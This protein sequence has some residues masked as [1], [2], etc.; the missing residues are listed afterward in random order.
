MCLLFGGAGLNVC[1]ILVCIYKHRMLAKFYGQRGH[2]ISKFPKSQDFPNV[3]AS[4]FIVMKYV[5]CLLNICIQTPDVN[6][7]HWQRCHE[8][9]LNFPKSG[10]M[11]ISR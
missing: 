5:W 2:E 6:K 11:S 10:D 3:F 4:F 1:D 8:I 9:Y 7:F